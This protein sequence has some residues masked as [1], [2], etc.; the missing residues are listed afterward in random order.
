MWVEL[1]PGEVDCVAL[2]EGS[3]PH[4]GIQGG[5]EGLQAPGKISE[6]RLSLSWVPHIMRL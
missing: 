4:W 3:K 2:R 6:R 5:L 1:N